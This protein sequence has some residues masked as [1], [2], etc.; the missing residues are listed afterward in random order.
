MKPSY[1]ESLISDVKKL[2]AKFDKFV[3]GYMAEITV[4]ERTGY[5]QD[6]LDEVACYTGKIVFCSDGKQKCVT[7]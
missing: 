4:M 1:R 7:K 3:K 6:S 2:N 5:Y